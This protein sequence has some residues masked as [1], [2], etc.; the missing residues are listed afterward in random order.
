MGEVIY[1]SVRNVSHR[2]VG[3]LLELHPKVKLRSLKENQ[4]HFFGYYDK[5]PWDSEGKRVLYHRHR[6]GAGIDLVVY[7]L[8]TDHATVIDTSLAWNWQQGA[9]LQWWPGSANG[10]VYN[11]IVNDRKLVAIIRD[12]VSNEI[13]KSLPM[14]I[15]TVNRGGKSAIS[16][17]Y[18]RLARL[19]PAYGYLREVDNFAPHQ[20]Y[21]KDGLWLIN[22]EKSTADL[23]LS[24]EKLINYKPVA[25]MQEAQH[26][27]NHAMYAPGNNRVAF[28]HRWITRNGKIDRLFTVK[29][30]GSELFLLADD[31]MSS[32][33]SWLDAERLVAYCRKKPWGN[34]YFLFRDQTNSVETVGK[35]VLDTRGDGH[36]TFSPDGRWIITDT[37]PDHDRMQELLLYDTIKKEK[38]VVGRFFS[39]W[40]FVKT[41]RCD[42]H[43]RWSPDGK[44]ISI[45]SVHSGRRAMFLLDI[46]GFV[47]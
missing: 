23:V 16:L 35:G 8:A 34:G 9:M 13:V 4:Q 15:Q 46:S 19:Q 17:N 3:S 22:V 43:P 7:E 5:T 41:V 33:H 32:H 42:L 6:K 2:C 37:Y 45:D 36:P 11:T 40:N 29:D 12:C 24:I 10:V 44:W 21:D 47:S 38:Q 20:E 39:P 14:P 26:K 1:G 30:D 18:R 25:S 27:L 28:L 31:G